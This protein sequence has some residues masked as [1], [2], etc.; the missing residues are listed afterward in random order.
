[1]NFQDSARNYATYEEWF[2]HIEEYTE[3][4]RKQTR[5][6]REEKTD[7]VAL[8]TMHH[9]KDWSIRLFLSWMPMRQ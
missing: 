6:Q 8:A 3:Q 7:G 1:M 9:S 4:L 2:G 5:K